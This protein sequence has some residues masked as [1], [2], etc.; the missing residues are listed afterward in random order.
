MA[1]GRRAE[2]GLGSGWWVRERAAWET[3]PLFFCAF[4][5][6]LPL[7]KSSFTSLN[8]L[9]FILLASSIVVEFGDRNCRLLDATSSAEQDQCFAVQALGLEHH[10]PKERIV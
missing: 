8:G 2:R 3:R 6:F 7:L 1:I 4:V 9:L 5:G 10:R